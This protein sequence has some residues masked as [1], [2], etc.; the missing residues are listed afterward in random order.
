MPATRSS[1]LRQ[2]RRPTNSYP[3]PL[4]ILQQL[5]ARSTPR[6]LLW[7]K[8]CRWGLVVIV[9]M[10]FVSCLVALSRLR[11]RLDNLSA[12][13]SRGVAAVQSILV[14]T[15]GWAQSAPHI[16]DFEGRSSKVVPP[17]TYQSW[18]PYSTGDLRGTPPQKIHLAQNNFSQ[19]QWKVRITHRNHLYQPRLAAAI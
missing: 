18:G 14:R 5:V 4:V 7:R 13:R 2:L 10:V 15:R 6:Q 16:E 1:I 17:E 12:I 11:P 8:L 19:G 9:G 3:I